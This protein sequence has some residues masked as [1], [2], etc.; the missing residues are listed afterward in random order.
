MVC[1]RS[2]LQRLFVKLS[3]EVE[4]LD[5]F[6]LVVQILEA[7]AVLHEQG[8]EYELHASFIEVYNETLRDLLAPGGRDAGRITDQNAIR[9]SAEGRV[10]TT[11]CV[12]SLPVLVCKSNRLLYSSSES[13]HDVFVCAQAATQWWWVPSGCPSQAAPTRTKSSRRLR[14]R[15]LWKQLP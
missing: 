13:T 3:T 5:G 10:F 2:W 12:A 15:V 11:I 9:H 8:W 6:T 1:A 14:R 7:V 4:L